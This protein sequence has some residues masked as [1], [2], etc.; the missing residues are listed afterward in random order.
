[1]SIPLVE[2]V[3]LD[4]VRYPVIHIVGVMAAPSTPPSPGIPY[5]ESVEDT[6]YRYPVFVELTGTT[7]VPTGGEPLVKTVEFNGIRYNCIVEADTTL[8]TSGNVDSVVIGGNRY[9][10]AVK[11]TGVAGPIVPNSPRVESAIVNGARYPTASFSAVTTIEVVSSAVVRSFTSSLDIKL[12]RAV[13]FDNAGTPCDP[14][15]QFTV[16]GSVSGAH[17]ITEVIRHASIWSEILI[18]TTTSFVEGETVTWSYDGSGACKVI[19]IHGDVMPSTP[20]DASNLL[21]ACDL[22]VGGFGGGFWHDAEPWLDSC[23]ILRG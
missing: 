11:A 15:A 14:I 19:D 17:T 22:S 3:F 5:I 4:G 18:T 13:I 9:P 16:T 10:C 1:M 7:V 6:G 8:S 12:S 21:T 20:H 23:D 2:S